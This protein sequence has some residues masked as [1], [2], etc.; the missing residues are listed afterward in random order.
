MNAIEHFAFWAGWTIYF[1]C[2]PMAMM[3]LVGGFL[4]RMIESNRGIRASPVAQDI[5]EL[6]SQA[7]TPAERALRTRASVLRRSLFRESAAEDY[8]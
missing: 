4:E 5:T 6:D 7:D 8:S 2:L 3:T 1:S